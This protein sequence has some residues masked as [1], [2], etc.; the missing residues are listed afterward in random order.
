LLEKTLQATT[1]S[2]EQVLT[3]LEKARKDLKR[4][5][6]LYREALISE[7]SF[8]ENRFKVQGLEKQSASLKAEI[9]RLE[10]ELQ[11]KAVQAPFEGVVVKRHIERG[12][13]LSQGATVATIAKDRVVDIIVEVPEKILKYVKPGKKVLV[14]AGGRNTTGKVFTI[15]P[16]GDISTRTFPI[17]IRMRNRATL[18][19]GMEARVNLPTGRREKAFIVQRD[20]IIKMFGTPV[21]FAVVDSKAAM[22]PVTV[23]GYKGKTVGVY[24]EGLT[25][26]MNIVIKGNERLRNG[27]LVEIKD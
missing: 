12:E 11:K 18:V 4:A 14:K 5:E 20:A 10:I 6:S 16:S 26:G 25:E 2:Y 23:I 8:D 9:E 27:Q 13:W 21:V 7:Q 24:A 17:K 1:A 19:E 15:I 22:I 3:D